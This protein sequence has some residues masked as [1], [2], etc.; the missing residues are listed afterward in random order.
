MKIKSHTA[1]LIMA[2]LFIFIQMAGLIISMFT[3]KIHLIDTTIATAIYLSA[4]FIVIELQD[5]KNRL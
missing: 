4:A 5:I 3:Q 1:L 2:A